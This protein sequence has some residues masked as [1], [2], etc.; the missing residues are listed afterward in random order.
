[1]RHTTLDVLKIF[2]YQ[3]IHH[4]CLNI[5]RIIDH[6]IKKNLLKNSLIRIIRQNSRAITKILWYDWY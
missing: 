1:M 5:N 6:K 3:E 4:Y 2:I